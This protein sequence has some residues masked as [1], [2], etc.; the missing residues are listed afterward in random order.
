MT[1]VRGEKIW[2]NLGV[3]YMKGSILARQYDSVKW[4]WYSEHWS[5]IPLGIWK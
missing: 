1:M 3:V 2:A 4:F 5:E